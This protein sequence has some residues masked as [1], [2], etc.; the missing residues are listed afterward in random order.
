MTTE[1]ISKTI[2]M[3]SNILFWLCAYY[4]TVI[5]YK[6]LCISIYSKT[7]TIL[8]YSVQIIK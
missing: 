4:N 2:K 5:Y 3:S 8:A 1:N 6:L 7:V